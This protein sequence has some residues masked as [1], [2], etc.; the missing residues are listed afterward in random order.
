MSLRQ[1]SIL[2]A[3]DRRTATV[4]I[5]SVAALM[6]TYL[7]TSAWKS[8]HTF[9]TGPKTIDVQG[10]ATRHMAPDNVSWTITLNSHA[11]DQETA[12]AAL[13]SNAS[14]VHD[15][16]VQHGIKDAELSFTAAST[17]DSSET[18]YDDSGNAI[19]PETS[20][21]DATQ[22]I[23]ITVKDIKRG[24]AAHDAAAI[25]DELESVE[26]GEAACSVNVPDA[27][28]DALLG[29]ARSNV[30]AQAKLALAQYGGATLGKLAN[31]SIGGVDIGSDCADI[32]LTANAS[33][34][35]EIR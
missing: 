2:S 19:T 14:T 32:V 16:L 13:R 20:D 18:T 3:F 8:I 35:Y 7:V 17:T 25:S 22:D 31:A 24:V 9:P 34:T 5:V 4:T 30:R 10:Q 21:W 1:P 33:A 29:Q 11:E 28:K 6:T 26:V 15:Y 23:V 12:R 27:A